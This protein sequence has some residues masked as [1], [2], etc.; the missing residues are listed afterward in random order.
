[1]PARLVAGSGALLVVALLHAAPAT[2]Q[3]LPT[4]QP[5]KPCYVTAGTRKAP[6]S[7]PVQISAAGFTPNSQVDLMIDGRLARGGRGLQT[8][9][10]GNLP[11]PPIE[12]PYVRRGSRAFTVTL[13][14]QGNSANTVSTT[15]K[16]TALSVRVRPTTAKPS[17]RIR[18]KGLGFTADLPI[19]AHYLLKGKLRKTVVMARTPGECG[20]FEVYRRQIPIK[21]PGL[22][23]WT[24]QFDQSEQYVDPDVTAIVYVQLFIR[25]ELVRR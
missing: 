16:S 20:S 15:A 8:D 17:D 10:A 2:A 5:L 4:I 22:G 9:A 23:M 18:F 13:T 6:T 21:R 11:I 14:E 1:M 12:A 7:E 19:Y 25:L 3:A 24:V